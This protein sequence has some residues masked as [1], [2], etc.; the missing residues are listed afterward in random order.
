M[1]KKHIKKL[2]S[3]VLSAVMVIG[4]STTAFAATP[5]TLEEAKELQSTLTI[6][7]IVTYQVSV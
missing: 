3:I 4:M 2:V 7:Q 5:M 6:Q 1:I